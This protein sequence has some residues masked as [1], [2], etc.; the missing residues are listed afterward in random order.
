MAGNIPLVGFFDLMCVLISGHDCLYK[1]SSKDSILI[2]YICKLLSEIDPSLPLQRLNGE[3]LD[4]IIATGN[5]NTNRYFR[6]L[7]HN[8]PV[9]FRS[10]RYSIAVL[11][12][13]ETQTD[14]EGLRQDIFTYFG[15]GCRNVSQ[16]FLS[17]NYDVE[18]LIEALQKHPIT[19]PPYLH[20]Y[21]QALALNTMQGRS[22]TDCL[23]F[24]LRESREPS[25]MISE[26]TYTYYDALPEVDNWISEHND[27]IQCIVSNHISY[28]RWIHFGQAQH[29]TLTDYPDGIDVMKFL[30]DL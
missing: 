2:D 10:S 23:F 27:Q 14:L 9:L 4:A 12:G 17:R 6:A 5:D 13:D 20:N 1:P 28:P 18:P 25:Q 7:Y 15:M 24:L 29:P 26:L 11:D 21:R 16:L 22:F 19:H 3:R 30:L 8:M